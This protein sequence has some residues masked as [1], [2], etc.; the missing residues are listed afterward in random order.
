MPLLERQFTIYAMDRRGRG[1]SADHPAYA[2][3]REYED[4]AAVVDG[5]GE[6][7]NVLGH[8]YGAL[9]ALEGALL[10]THV[11]RLVLYEPGFPTNGPLYTPGL[12]ERLEA[13]LA[14]DARDEALAT[15][16]REVVGLPA[17][18]VAA[19]Q[20]APTWEMRR[21]IAHTLPREFA[22]GDYVFDGRRIAQLHIPVLLLSGSDSPE[23]LRAP[24]EALHAALPDST[25]EIIEQQGHIAMITAPELFAQ[26]VIDF[27]L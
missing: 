3:E 22:D 14:S 21:S 19:M 2:L 7:T 23:E 24:T 18:D 9:C 8:S 10:T 13:S 17:D 26:L 16:Y 25:V 4:V 11:R 5:I 6:A 1:L 12:R 20:Q 15:F 27:L